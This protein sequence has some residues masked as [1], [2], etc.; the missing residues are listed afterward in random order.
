[1][2]QQTGHAMA[3]TLFVIAQEVSTAVN[4]LWWFCLRP[5]YSV[6]CPEQSPRWVISSSY[7]PQTVSLLQEFPALLRLMREVAQVVG[8]LALLSSTSPCFSTVV[9]P[10]NPLWHPWACPKRLSLVKLLTTNLMWTKC[11][12]DWS[13]IQG[14]TLLAEHDCLRRM[15]RG[16]I[17]GTCF[18]HFSIVFISYSP[19]NVAVSSSNCIVSRLNVVGHIFYH[20]TSVYTCCM[21]VLYHSFSSGLVCHNT[22]VSLKYW[23]SNEGKNVLT[24]A[25]TLILSS[26]VI[27]HSCPFQ[28]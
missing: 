23:R 10:S 2:V 25:Q 11:L 13:N 6:G 22:C 5:C 8:M 28:H 7:C 14:G 21:V 18:S 17:C 19:F 24:L 27:S 1:M 12:A 20:H 4:S 16:F 26:F 3:E 9:L 15:W